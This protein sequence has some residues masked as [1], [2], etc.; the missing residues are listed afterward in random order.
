MAVVFG[1]G[2]ARQQERSAAGLRKSTVAL[3]FCVSLG[4]CAAVE[5]NCFGCST[6]YSSRCNYSSVA[7]TA[8]F[9]GTLA[10]ACLL[11]SAMK[12]LAL[13][14]PRFIPAQQSS[15]SKLCTM[16]TEHSFVHSIRRL[17][18][19]KVKVGQW[20]SAWCVEFRLLPEPRAETVRSQQGSQGHGLRECGRPTLGRGASGR[21]RQR[22]RRAV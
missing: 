10:V 11:L 21:G 4:G 19:G 1:P 7:V 5:E 22:G 2:M 8:T 17:E 3:C 20:C 18:K 15:S 16:L 9:A 13:P 14:C 6:E 12:I